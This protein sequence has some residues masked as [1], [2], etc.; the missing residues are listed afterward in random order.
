M[1]DQSKSV[2]FRVERAAAGAADGAGP[3][4][5]LR[6]PDERAARVRIFAVR[7]ATPSALD[8]ALR[9]LELLLPTG[10]M[11]ESRPPAPPPS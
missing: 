2:A 4:R 10:S 8:A 3:L 6:A 11:R 7:S 9:S 1:A 5:D